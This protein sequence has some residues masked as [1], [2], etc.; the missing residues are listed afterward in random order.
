MLLVLWAATFG[1]DEFGSSIK[2]D[3]SDNEQAADPTTVSN[4]TRSLRRANHGLSING[5][6]SSKHARKRYREKTSLMLR[7]I[8]ELVDFHGIMR[9]PTFDTVRILLLIL[10]LLEGARFHVNFVSLHLISSRGISP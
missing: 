3:C 10:P 6:D 2:D 7:E 1:V 5:K 9:R 8:L 4:A